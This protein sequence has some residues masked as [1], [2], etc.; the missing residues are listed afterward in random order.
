[1]PDSSTVVPKSTRPGQFASTGWSL[2]RFSLTPVIIPG[3]NNLNQ[4]VQ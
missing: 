1:M 3:L 2:S 4:S